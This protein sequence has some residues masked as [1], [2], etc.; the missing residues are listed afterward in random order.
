MRKVGNPPSP[1]RTEPAWIGRMNLS[2]ICA[3]V[4]DSHAASSS[5]FWWSGWACTSCRYPLWDRIWSSGRR[6]STPARTERPTTGSS[7]PQRSHSVLWGLFALWDSKCSWFYWT[8]LS[9]SSRKG[10][11]N[12]RNF[13]LNRSLP[14]A[15]S[16]Y[17]LATKTSYF[18]DTSQPA[19]HTYSSSLS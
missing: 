19:H 15:L 6:E 18:P 1:S 16:A 17:T 2:Q 13:P 4:L 7:H 11:F 3:L 5:L 12:H 10:R 9:R 8:T 14:A